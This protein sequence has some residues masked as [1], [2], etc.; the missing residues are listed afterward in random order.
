MMFLNRWPA[1]LLALGLLLAPAIPA[2]SQSGASQPLPE[3]APLASLVRAVDIPY[4]RFT[5]ENG[6]TVLVHT[7]R[8]APIVSVQVWYHVGSKDEPPGK[9]GFAHL[10]EHLMFYGSENSD[11]PWFN[12]LDALGATQLN[13]TTSFDR[14][15]YFQNVPTPALDLT[16]WLESDRMGYLLGAVTQAKLDAQRSVVQ[17]EKRQGDNQPLGLTRYA[18]QAALFPKGHPYH[19][20]TIG[21]MADLDAAS[22]AD[23]RAWFRSH[24]GPN[25]AVL[26]LA[27]DIDAATARPMVERWFGAIPRGPEVKRRDAPVPVW[28]E[29]RRETL[30][31][32]IPTPRVARYWV[33]PGQTT[34]DATLADI[35]L[36]ILAG[37]S[38]SRL[39]N[40]LVRETRL[41]VGINGGVS[42]FEKVGWGSI[43]VTL[44]PGSD[45]AAIEAE[46]D[47]AMAQFLKEG[48]T[49]DELQRVA[50]RAVSGTIR[51]LEAIGG[52]GGKGATLAEGQLYAGD[53][54]FFK[55]DLELYASATAEAVRKAANTWLARGDYRQTVLPGERPRA[56]ESA[57]PATP[58][59]PAPPITRVQRPPAPAVAGLPRLA[60][61]SLERATLSNGIPVTLARRDA[62][63]V[64]RIVA[65]FE[66]GRASDSPDMP[67]IAGLALAMLDEGTTSRSGPEIAEA[68]ERLGANISGG[69]GPDRIS[70]SLDALVPNLAPSLALFADVLRNPAFPAP[71][72]E[73]VR[74]QA[75]AALARELS[76]PNGI[77]SRLLPPLLYGP[78]H[79]YGVPASGTAQSL[80][81]LTREALAGWHRQWIRPDTLAL[82]VVGDIDMATLLPALEAALGSWQPP[83]SPRPTI[84]LPPA[85]P[86]SPRILLIDRP[87]SPQTIL[88]G[89]MALPLTGRDDPLALRAANDVLGG[90][91]A[92]RLNVNIR[93]T[94]GW[95]YGIGSGIADH[96]G[97]LT[98]QVASSVQSDR[99]VDA[100]LAI[101]ADIEA[102]RTGA[103]PITP[104]ERDDAI[105]GTINSLPG[106]YES[107]TA[108]LSA[109]T[110]NAAMDRPDDYQATLTPRLAT[111]QPQD[112]TRAATIL[113]PAALTWLLVGDAATIRPQLE[114]AGLAFE[115]RPA[116]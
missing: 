113:N 86:P 17:N 37:G 56:E 64:V 69:V 112:L 11:E 34:P 26:V 109:L 50:T 101:N 39:Y 24:Y 76:S 65:S 62:V 115:Q 75:E 88:R 89:G 20:S 100:L 49:A 116:D 85:P 47:A 43:N 48:P 63:P 19:H 66:G 45:P 8:K 96:R 42:A 5:L 111:L 104:Q 79:P 25:N 6:L 61:P 92:S 15:N 98:F 60:A 105:N 32:T 38:S 84:T 80:K 18:T 71:E 1:A 10:F 55:A 102:L 70:F 81:A 3:P 13:G 27:G 103:R 73:R 31:D 52:F 114:K 23:V 44:A 74:G 106:A 14:T 95:S 36:T 83:A 90:L 77:A 97:P 99:T 110:K 78:R 68:Q 16:L 87:G 28:T 12:K 51:G 30:R 59:E 33:L 54:L 93:E 7:D 72:F 41:A 94:R 29:T 108:L 53:P 22:L 46:I 91:A 4:Q 58:P 35:A 40:R 2:A 9:T 67:G 82:F 107:G 57:P 21:S